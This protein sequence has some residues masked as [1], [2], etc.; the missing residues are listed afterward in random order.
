M[1]WGLGKGQ[2]PPNRQDR[3]LA[4]LDQDRG[5][6]AVQFLGISSPRVYTQ[7]A[8]NSS[9][10]NTDTLNSSP[11]CGGG[12][13]PSYSGVSAPSL[14]S[15]CLQFG[16]YLPHYLHPCSHPTEGRTLGHTIPL[17]HSPLPGSP[18]CSSPSLPNFSP[19]KSVA[20]SSPLGSRRLTASTRACRRPKRQAK[21]RG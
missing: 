11:V 1:G 10:I 4:S 21:C 9:D 7:Q 8:S 17:G 2:V 15:L 6:Q 13:V 5:D 3:W 16:S 20:S 14:R 19:S 18:F 12:S